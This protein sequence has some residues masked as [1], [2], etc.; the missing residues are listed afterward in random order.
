MSVEQ[1]SVPVRT[2]RAPANIHDQSKQVYVPGQQPTVIWLTGLSGSGKST[3]ARHVESALRA[4]GHAV[5][6]IDGDAL[7]AGLCNDLG[8]TS[9]DRDENVR[10]AAEVAR[11]MSR[12]GLIVL[13]SLIS[14]FRESRAQA[15]SL[16]EPGQFFETYVDT[17]FNVAEARDPKRLYRKA[18]DGDIDNFT[19]LASP[20][21]RPES[22]EIRLDT[23]AHTPGEC[24]RIV[25]DALTCAGRIA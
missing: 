12:S 9:A 1:S 6:T 11:L 3:I 19:G 18:R 17:P 14:P 7:R 13:V 25:V 5:A 16:F 8:F 21:E 20:Y 10:R 23:V 22:P 2:E 4:R 15:R 24:A